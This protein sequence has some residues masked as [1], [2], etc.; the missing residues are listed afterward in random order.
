MSLLGRRY[1]WPINNLVSPPVCLCTAEVE[2]D[3]SILFEGPCTA[4]GRMF[5]AP[6]EFQIP[7]GL[8]LASLPLLQL[9]LRAERTPF[10][11]LHWLFFLFFHLPRNFI[12]VILG[13][14]LLLIFFGHLPIY[15][16]RLR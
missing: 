8:L 16:L 6:I 4:A 12:V 7:K 9:R 1:A 15:R 13:L 11:Y 2:R 3:R 5:W 10:T 14:H